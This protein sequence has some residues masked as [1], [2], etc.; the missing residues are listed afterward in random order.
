MAWLV[1]L[2]LCCRELEDRRPRLPLSW[3]ERQYAAVDELAYLCADAVLRVCGGLCVPVPQSM[4]RFVVVLA[5]GVMLVCF[6]RLPVPEQQV[7]Q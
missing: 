5:G 6:G 1:W 4:A 3:I 2:V 7:P